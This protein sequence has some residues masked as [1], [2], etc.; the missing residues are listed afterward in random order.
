MDMEDVTTYYGDEK[1]ELMVHI[2]NVKSKNWHDTK[3]QL[4]EWVVVME[5]SKPFE[6]R[7]GTL[8]KTKLFGTMKLFYLVLVLERMNSLTLGTNRLNMVVSGK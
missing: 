8:H 4:L 3:N 5:E 2:K 1:E 6:D 7:F